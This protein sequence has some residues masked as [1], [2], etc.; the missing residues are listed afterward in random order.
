MAI[1]FTELELGNIDEKIQHL[2]LV[3][4]TNKGEVYVNKKTEDIKNALAAQGTTCRNRSTKKRR[5]RKTTT[6]T[7]SSSSSSSSSRR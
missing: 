1:T 6:S 2:V 5:R 7:S 3:G 4:F